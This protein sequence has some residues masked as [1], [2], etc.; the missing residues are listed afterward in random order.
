MQAKS[1]L[2]DIG[3]LTLATV[4]PA[5]RDPDML[6][7]LFKAGADAFRVNLSHGD[8][9]THAKTIKAVRALEKEFNRPI[10]VLCEEVSTDY[11]CAQEGSKRLRTMSCPEPPIGA[12]VAHAGFV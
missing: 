5:S 11:A 10:A 7:R 9:A 4:G 6:R 2:L 12:F 1:R 8:H 3:L